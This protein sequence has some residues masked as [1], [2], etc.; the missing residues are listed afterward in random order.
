MIN[1]NKVIETLISQ[2]AQKATQF[3]N[4]KLIIRATRKTYK[5][6]TLTKK[7]TRKFSRKGDNIEITLTIGKPNWAEKEFIK[8]CIKA[9]EP[10]PIK[11]IQLKILNNE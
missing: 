1:Y 9:N 5:N 4:E 11:K 10:F 8:K 7:T 2:N 6:S 3:I